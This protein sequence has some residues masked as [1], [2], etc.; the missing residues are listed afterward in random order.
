MM[1]AREDMSQQFPS[2]PCWMSVG[3]GGIVKRVV[4]G[5]GRKEGGRRKVKEVAAWAK[6]DDDMEDE[7]GAIERRVGGKVESM[8]WRGGGRRVRKASRGMVLKST[9]GLAAAKWEREARLTVISERSADWTF[10]R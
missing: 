2:M 7:E 5:V 1:A 4:G 3:W 6:P 9:V 8:Y 10:S